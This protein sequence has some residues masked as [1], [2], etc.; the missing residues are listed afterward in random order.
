MTEIRGGAPSLAGP[1]RGAL[2]WA[3]TVGAGVAATLAALPFEGAASRWTALALYT[4]VAALAV[5]R[6]AAF[7]PHGRF[8]LA[9]GI[10]TLR[11]GGA[12]T[13]AALLVEP[14][15]LGPGGAWGAV[16]ATAV[17]LALDAGDGAA[18][19]C[20]GLASRFG[21]RFDMEVDA[22][23]ILVL[24]ALALVLGK[25][26]PWV[27]GIGLMRYAF[28]AAGWLWPGLDRPLPP[29]R[30]RSATCALQVAVLGILLAP[31]VQP[32]LSTALAAVA[33][34]ALLAS[35]AR[36]VWWLARQ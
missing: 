5:E 36:D 30:R 3:A 1:R 2:A 8:G 10:T 4:L 13:L 17:L 26:G 33:L 31:V 14:A 9:N 28:V 20:Q 15:A 11:A 16:A 22:A 12:A 18:A 27:L 35:F 24:S 23:L 6:V 19:R 29:S 21:A 25:A 32:P 7:H 34:L